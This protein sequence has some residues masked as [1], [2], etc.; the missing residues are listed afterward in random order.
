MTSRKPRSLL[1]LLP[2]RDLC[3]SATLIFL[4]LYVQLTFQRQVRC[5]HC[6]QHPFLLEVGVAKSCGC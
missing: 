5:G 4:H 3:V 1:H 6:Q 2:L